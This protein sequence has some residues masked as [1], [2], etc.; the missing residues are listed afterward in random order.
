MKVL[1]PEMTRLAQEDQSNL[2][3]NAAPV[4]E[5][6]AKLTVPISSE[7]ELPLVIELKHHVIPLNSFR[8][9]GI[10]E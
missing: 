1:N 8:D 3:T 7:R 6:E 10:N 5:A 9:F 4:P 2:D